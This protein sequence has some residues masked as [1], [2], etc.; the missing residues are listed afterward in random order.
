MEPW[1]ALAT[2]TEPHVPHVLGY[3]CRTCGRVSEP[4]PE[5]DDFAPLAAR[6]AGCGQSIPQPP[7]LG[8]AQVERHFEPLIWW[9]ALAA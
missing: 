2:H 7:D 1:N 5:H 6:C 4:A 8:L 3:R 9:D